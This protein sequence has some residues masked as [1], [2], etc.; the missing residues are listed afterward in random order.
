MK[1]GSE[2]K[3]KD[4]VKSYAAINIPGHVSTTVYR[5]DSGNDEYLMSVVFS[6]KAAYEKNADSP[7]QNKRFQEM[8]TLLAGEP[9]WMDGEIIHHGK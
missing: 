1:P 8:M 6:D 4:L 9:Q 7:E 2:S 5:L 3:M